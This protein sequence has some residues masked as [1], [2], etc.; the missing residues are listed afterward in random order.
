MSVRISVNFKFL[1]K[2]YLNLANFKQKFTI[3]TL[4]FNDKANST[5]RT[6]NAR[7]HS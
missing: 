4:L 3:I 2:I 7:R 5:Q 1:P 6:K